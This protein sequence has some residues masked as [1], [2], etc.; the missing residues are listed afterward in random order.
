MS[1]P[2]VTVLSD[3]SSDGNL[4]VNKNVVAPISPDFLKIVRGNFHQVNR[5]WEFFFMLAI[6]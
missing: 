5:F 2:E 4:D 1:D 6:L 3:D